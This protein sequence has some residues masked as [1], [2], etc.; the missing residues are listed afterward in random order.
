MQVAVAASGLGHIVRGIEAWADDLAKCGAVQFLY[1]GGGTAG[2]RHE[3]VVR[4]AQRE[5]VGTKRLLHI[6]PRSLGWRIGLG[7]GYCIEQTTFALSLLPHLRRQRIDIV[8]V[9]DPLVAIVVHRARRL[10]LV[11]TRVVLAHGTE[12]PLEFIRRFDY[13]QHLAPWHLEEARAAGVWKPTWTAIPNFIDTGR[14][15]PGASPIRKELGIPADAVVVLTAAAIKR[16]HKRIDYLIDEFARLREMRPELPAY[17]I[18]AGGWEAETDE[19]LAYG[20]QRLGERVRFLVRFPRERMPDLYRAADV[21]TLCSLKEMM[22]IA[23]LEATASGL[24]CVVNR[25]PVMQWM[26]GPG[27]AAIDMSGPGALAVTLGELLAAPDARR[28]L[29]EA[30]RGHCMENFSKDRVVDQ[31]LDYYRFVM[32]HDKPGGPKTPD[33]VR[34]HRDAGLQR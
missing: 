26:I 27:G 33:E 16:G 13:L 31:I 18:V 9:Q 6:L 8:H 14:F 22:P 17:L 2:T 29:G 7:S 28:S 21:F 24:P 19:L 11:R 4:C 25:H 20:R 32:T 34:V 10:R 15:A 12:E 5:W 23:L 1:R 3:R 30:A